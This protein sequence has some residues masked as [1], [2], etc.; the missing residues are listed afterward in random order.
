M[1]PTHCPTST[2]TERQ[3]VGGLPARLGERGS[4]WPGGRRPGRGHGGPRRGAP[5][6][7]R[8]R[9]AGSPPW[10]LPRL[11]VAGLGRRWPNGSRAPF[12]LVAA[13]AVVDVAL[14][15]ARADAWVHHR[16]KSAPGRRYAAGVNR[17]SRLL[18]L[19]SSPCSSRTL[20]GCSAG[21]VAATN[22]PYMPSNGTSLT[23]G[24]MDARNLLLVADETQPTPSSSSAP[25]S[26]TAQVPETLTAV[27]VEGAGADRRSRR[28]RSPVAPCITTGALADEHDR[29][30]R[31]HLR[32]RRLHHDHLD[33]RTQGSGTESLLALTREGTTSGG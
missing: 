2:R 27:T 31:R 32:G 4:T 8:D 18:T 17:P 23:V 6:A 16:L 11:L 12:V 20:A 15:V 14:L 30:A 3:G 28:S 10:P 19:V 22:R 9:W 21:F 26:T 29:G 33:L 25:W 1:P 13:V 7:G 5:R 24:T